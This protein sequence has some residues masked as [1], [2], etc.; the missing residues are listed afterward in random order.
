MVVGVLTG[1]FLSGRGGWS[2]VGDG[3]Q[4]RGALRESVVSRERAL[5]CR[6]I[7]KGRQWQR[8][9]LGVDTRLGGCVLGWLELEGGVGWALRDGLRFTV[10]GFFFP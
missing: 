3:C 6:P 7:S 5:A 10:F 1:Y 2:A 9:I 4:R 8:I